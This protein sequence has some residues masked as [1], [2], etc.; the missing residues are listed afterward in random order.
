MQASVELSSEQLTRLKGVGRF[1]YCSLKKAIDV[2]VDLNQAS[3]FA[4]Q[5][6][7]YF[8]TPEK[9]RFFSTLL[10][11]KQWEDLKRL[12]QVVKTKQLILPFPELDKQVLINQRTITE[13]ENEIRNV[14]L[15]NPN[16]L[17]QPLQLSKI[18]DITREYNLDTYGRSDLWIR[19]DRVGYP[20]EIKDEMAD[21]KAVGQ[22]GKYI[23][24]AIDLMHLSSYDW[25]TG[26]LIA[27]GF[28]G[29]ALKQM[30]LFDMIAIQVF[31]DNKKFRFV[32]L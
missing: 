18:D 9:Q 8:D 22:V 15:D 27:P 28:S 17:M 6:K 10:T 4:N 31:S 5:I 14:I 23:R 12:L 13:Y 7:L 26:V 25:V 3:V 19:S 2:A 20:I 21:S 1:F 24:G 29:D 16:C 11:P 32:R 30:R